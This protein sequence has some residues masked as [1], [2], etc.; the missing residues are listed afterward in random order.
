MAV[1][2]TWDWIPGI[3]KFGML[4]S[5]KPH[6]NKRKKMK[7]AIPLK[8]GKESSAVSPMFGHAKWFAFADENGDI[9]IVRN[10]HDGGMQV[11]QWLLEN[12]MTHALTSHMGPGPFRLFAERG[13]EVYHPGE[14]RVLLTEA[15]EKFRAGTLERITPDNLDKIAGHHH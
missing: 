12:G 4:F 9:E 15:I 14:G 1:K 7:I 13:I 10:P 8:M 2:K 6:Y 5:E 11:V 3:R